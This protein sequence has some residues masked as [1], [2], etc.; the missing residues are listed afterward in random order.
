MPKVGDTKWVML[1]PGTQAVAIN[2]NTRGTVYTF[3]EEDCQYRYHVTYAPTWNGGSPAN[4]D[5]SPDWHVY[6]NGESWLLK[7]SKNAF[8]SEVKIPTLKKEFVTLAVKGSEWEFTQDWTFNGYVNLFGKGNNQF[9][10]IPAGTRVKIVDN[11]MRMAWYSP[12]EKCIVAEL[13]PGLEVFADRQYFTGNIIENA[14]VHIPAR[15]ASQYLKLVK[16][17]KA[18]TYW[19]MEDSQ[20]NA[21][22]NKRFATLG[23]LKSSLRVRF[24]LVR[25]QGYDDD[26]PEWVQF[27]GYERPDTSKGVFAVHYDHATDAEIERQDMSKFLVVSF[28]KA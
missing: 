20:G 25:G 24:G 5:E 6:H 1:K 26:A 18:K 4:N 17:G 15:E 23:N 10:T 2:Y 7:D 16:A 11:K 12:Q 8:A 13:A 3:T 21:W 22:V 9:H 19:K 27:D 28:L 14:P